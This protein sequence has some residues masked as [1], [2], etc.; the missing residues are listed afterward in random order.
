MKSSKIII[1]SI[2]I[3]LMLVGIIFILLSIK[4]NQNIQEKQNSDSLSVN[5]TASVKEIKGDEYN[6]EISKNEEMK[7]I[8]GQVKK[9]EEGKIILSV[10]LLNSTDSPDLKERIIKFNKDVKVYKRKTKKEEQ[11][12]KELK[13][14]ET[15]VSNSTEK[16]EVEI[17][18]TS[19]PEHFTQEKGFLNDI[20]ESDFI[21]IVSLSNIREVKNIQA[22]E[23]NILD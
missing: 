3:I 8:F 2:I 6:P 4:K 11:F 15:I 18:N 17:G 13:E 10:S 5:S 22:V 1:A 9:I 14:F 7:I 21:N 12:K 20:K 19:I 23:I 16:N